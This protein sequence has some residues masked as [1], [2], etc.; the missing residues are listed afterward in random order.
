MKRNVGSVDRL[1][2]IVVGI[3]IAI[4]GVVFNSWWGLIGIVPLATGLFNFCPLYIPFN[5]STAKKGD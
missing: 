5:I 4:A 1:L 3:L 2:R